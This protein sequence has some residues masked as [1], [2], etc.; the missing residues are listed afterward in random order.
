M[1]TLCLFAGGKHPLSKNYNYVYFIFLYDGG[2]CEI[3]YS[4]TY[5]SYYLY[6]IDDLCV[7]QATIV[8]NGL[9]YD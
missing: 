8:N 9:N 3:W 2:V 5:S 1:T 6:V 4:L 7:V